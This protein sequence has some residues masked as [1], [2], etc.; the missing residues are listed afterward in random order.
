MVHYSAID[1]IRVNT[2]S[3]NYTWNDTVYTESGTYQQVFQTVDGCDSTVILI[4]TFDGTEGID[5][6]A[7][8]GIYVYPNPT[9][10]MLYLSQQVG[11]VML[12]DMVGRMV[13]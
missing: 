4:L 13:M 6:I 3:L 7:S 12:Y 10:G 2:G 9:H 11:E 8:D 5:D 1:T